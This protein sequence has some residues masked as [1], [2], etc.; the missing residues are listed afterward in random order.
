MN[1]EATLNS[2]YTLFL[3][4]VLVVSFV[5]LCLYYGL[6]WMRVAR[7]KNSKMPQADELKPADLPSVSVVIVSHNESEALKKSLP[8]LL[9]QDYPNYE[10]VVVDYMSS[11]DTP[12]VLRVCSENYTNLKVVNFKADVNMFKGKKYP[13]SIGIKSAVGDVVLLTEPDCR[14]GG[15]DWVS[16]MVCGYM[17]GASMV[18][19][20][21][22]VNTDKGLLNAL[23][24]YENMV[25]TASYVGATIMG[26][27]YTATGRNLSYRRDFF[28][29]RGGFISHYSFPDGADDLFVNQNA[30]RSNTVV[31]LRDKAAV[32]CD[33]SR[34]LGE[35]RQ[36]RLH[37]RSPRRFYGIKDRLS[38]ALY[39]LSQLLFLASLVLLFV[40]GIFPW[41]MLVALLAVKIIWQIVCCALLANRFKI[42]LLQFFSPFF[43][44]YFLFSDTILSISALRKKN[45]QWR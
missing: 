37:R 23:E 12:F 24:R 43:E 3:L 22:L 21:S 9:E 39:P 34:T 32:M 16:E 45:V 30:N 18:L 14:P 26:N 6:M 29:N 25:F 35:W 40:G 15:F 2:R 36:K 1:F 5:A 11:D 13:L 8:Y 7:Y 31:D 41:Q 38:L 27:P 4:V 33:E 19:G 20:Y 10:V 44:L 17:H 28:F 42:K